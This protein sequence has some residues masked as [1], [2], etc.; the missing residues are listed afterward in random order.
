MQVYVYRQIEAL[1]VP[2]QHHAVS[3]LFR[4]LVS[5]FLDSHG[6]SCCSSTLKKKQKMYAGV[7]GL[8]AHAGLD[9]GP[10]RRLLSVFAGPADLT[11]VEGMARWGI[12]AIRLPMNEDCWLGLHG[13]DSAFSG[14]N[15]QDRLVE[16]TE[17]LLSHGFVVVLGTWRRF[18]AFRPLVAAQLH[19]HSPL[20][21]ACRFALD[22]QHW[23]HGSRAR[24]S[25]VAQFAQI[26][27]ER[28]RA[29][30]AAEQARSCL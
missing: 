14:K 2:Q 5:L 7:C 29:P 23:R 30:S 19:T 25:H 26:L 8:G 6:D 4:M 24:L 9:H 28:C 10:R 18:F 17:L 3:Q 27:G 21:A 11:V 22:E 15:Y 1:E 13:V 20:R 12:N 16:F